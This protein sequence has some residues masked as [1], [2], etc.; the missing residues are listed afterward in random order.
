MPRLVHPPTTLRNRNR[1]TNKYRLKIIHGNID[2]DPFI[3][4]EDDE[5]SRSNLAVAGVDQ[6]DANEHHLQAVLNEAAQRNYSTQRTTRGANDKK[7]APPAAYI[8]TPDSTGIVDNY[9]QL[10]PSNTWKDPSTYVCTST[11]VEEAISNALAHDCTYYMDERDKEWLDKNNEEARGEGTSAQGAMS[12]SGVRASA[13]SAK[14]KGKEPESSSPVAV[15]EDEFELVMGL[16][17]KVTHEKTEHLHLVSTF[18]G[19]KDV[20]HPER[21]SLGGMP[22]PPFSDY[23]DTF[24]APLVPTDF[25]AFAV[26][27]WIPPPSTLVR[28]ARAI[29]PHWKERRL[30]REGHRII[31]I[32]NGDE[33]DVLN[34]SYICFRRREIKA[35]RKTRASTLTSSDKLLRL[36]GEF[37]YPLDLATA[38]LAREN[39]KQECARQSQILWEKRLAVADLKRKFPTLGDQSDA[40]LLLE[41]ERPAKKPEPSASA[42]RL[43]GLKIRTPND[44][45]ATPRIEPVMRPQARAAMIQSK[46]DIELTRQRDHHWEDG[47]NNSYQPPAVAYTSRLF[48]YVPPPSTP[49]WPGSSAPSEDEPMVPVLRAVRV[50]V[51]RGG[52]IMLDRRRPSPASDISIVKSSRSALFGSPPDEDEDMDI[53]D[54]ARL[55]ERWRFDADDCPAV[56]PDG[57]DEQDRVLTDEYDP[58]YLRHSMCLLSEN[59]HQGLLTDTMLHFPTEGSREVTKVPGFKLG[60][61]YLMTRR[62]ATGAPRQ[63][64]PGMQQPMI[65]QQQPSPAPPTSVVAGTPIS[66]QIKKMQPAAGQHMRISSNGG[67]RP[68]GIPVVA[69][70]QNHVSPTHTSPPRASPP[71]PPSQQHSPVLNGT[72]GQVRGAMTM[73]HVDQSNAESAHAVQV[74]NGIIPSHQ[75]QDP[76][77]LLQPPENNMAN[78]VRANSPARPK[79]QNQHV[80]GTLPN[81]YQLG[82]TMNG[83][84]SYAA[85]ALAQA[86]SYLPQTSSGLSL[87]QMANIKSAFAANQSNSPPNQ[88]MQGMQSNGNRQMPASYMHVPNGANFNMPLA[89]GTNINLKLPPA[90]QM[91]WSSPMRPNSVVNGMD[92]AAMNGAMNGALNGALNGAMNGSMSP[93][94]NHRHAVPVPV[95]TP[96]ANGSRN[97]MRAMNGQL[98]AH[99]MSPHLQHSPSPMPSISQSQSPP[100]PPMTP[101]QMGSPSMQHQQPVGGFQNV[102]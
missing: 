49:S 97:G 20:A 4:D 82:A 41:K 99:S 68:P 78:G 80:N 60:M 6:E 28:I 98:N 38:V 57:A 59:D 52:R 5:K 37:S 16:F 46:I 7:T 89:G 96:S 63:F 1:I 55:K 15:N 69:S 64:P 92:S 56:G 31:P 70:M 53:E 72:N 66:T 102:Y 93:S 3:P 44:P 86:P 77:N 83:M 74:T 58:K 32:L 91:N 42:S 11:T 36:Q 24:A 13:R 35:V 40:D 30:E 101:M 67:M 61:Q 65:S 88:D 95:R 51:G 76:V 17:E 84:N 73:P 39:L 90:R 94:P 71:H 48:K 43:P 18:A 47:I 33:N 45:N 87:Q 22:F 34:E 81:G 26:P 25:A 100:R 50:R 23:N 27:S 85:S 54:V 14:A 2:T 62:D 9:E 10:Y 29:Y 21:Q 12:A 75:P 19:A 79:S 8:P